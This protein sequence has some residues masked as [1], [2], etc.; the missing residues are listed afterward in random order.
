V[1]RRLVALLL[2]LNVVVW[3]SLLSFEAAL[4]HESAV[5]AAESPSR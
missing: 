1:K 2:A 3:G 5:I 4:A